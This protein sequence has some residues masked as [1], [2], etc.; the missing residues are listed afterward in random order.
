MPSNFFV[1][2]ATSLFI[3]ACKNT[4]KITN[5]TANLIV[6]EQLLEEAEFEQNRIFLNVPTPNGQQVKFYTDTGGGKIINPATPDKLGLT[7]DSLREGERVMEVVNLSSFLEAQTLPPTISPQFVFRKKSPFEEQTDGMLGANW[8]ANKIWRFDYQNQQLSWVKAW[9][10]KAANPQHTVQLG[11][12]KNAL[13]KHSTHFPRISIIIEGDTIQT[14]FDSGATAVLNKEAKGQ[15]GDYYAIG[16]SFIVASFF[17]KWKAQH[18]EWKV[19]EGGDALLKED[20]I[21]VPKMTIAG[22]TVGPVW[23][24][25]RKEENFTQFMSKWMDETIHGAI[26]GSCFQYFSTIVVDYPK[27]LAYFQK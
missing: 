16:A 21:E 18:P 26:G 11:F 9:N 12:M 25:R 19:F 14:L 24:A 20:M 10:P 2:L 8:F 5:P 3:F 1:L 17:D 4:S 27:E 7:I 6:E 15:I 23:F 13:G 22:H